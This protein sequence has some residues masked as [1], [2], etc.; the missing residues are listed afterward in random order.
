MLIRFYHP[1]LFNIALYPLKFIV[2]SF[3]AL[4]FSL[5]FI[6]N[7]NFSVAIGGIFCAAW[8]HVCVL[9]HT[10]IY[11]WTIFKRTFSN[12]FSGLPWLRCE[13]WWMLRDLSLSLSLQH[14]HTHTHSYGIGS[15]FASFVMRS[16]AFT[17]YQLECNSTD[18]HAHI[19]LN[20]QHMPENSNSYI[21]KM[22][23]A[24]KQYILYMIMYSV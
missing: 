5:D 3:D 17:I 9:K 20:L 15:L 4:V 16:I 14:V 6:I 22:W 12:S 8:A 24:F 2:C 7:Q 19:N 1:E 11:V 13:K 10:H 21:N 18:T 23:I